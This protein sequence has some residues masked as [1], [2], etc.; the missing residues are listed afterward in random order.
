[1]NKITKTFV[2]GD[3]L[4]ASDLNDIV[5]SVNGIVD[6][7][8]TV[9][10]KAVDA[11]GVTAEAEATKINLKLP[12]IA[13]GSTPA[14]VAL[15]AVSSTKAGLFTPDMKS[16]LDGK[17]DKA[18]T[19]AGYEI[20]DAYTKAE[21]DAK[22]DEKIN[23]LDAEKSGSD[24][25]TNANIT[26]KVKEVDGKV[27]GVE[28]TETR[29]GSTRTA[30][31][32]HPATAADVAAGKAAKE[33]DL[34]VD[35]NPAVALTS[36]WGVATGD[37]IKNV[38]EYSEDVAK[39]EAAA[40]VAAMSS[41]A[42]KTISSH[43]I[44]GTGD[45]Q[46][47]SEDIEHSYS[48]DIFDFEDVKTG[49]N[50]MCATI[51]DNKEAIEEVKGDLLDLNVTDTA[52]DGKYVSAVEQQAGLI[53]VTREDLPVKEIKVTDGAT[54]NTSAVSV[55]SGVVSIVPAVN[56]DT[57]KTDA[58]QPANDIMSSKAVAAYV[59]NRLGDL[60][61]A[62]IYKGNVSSSSPLPAV[63]NVGDTY[64]V[65]EAGTYAGQDA[66]V[67]AMLI[68]ATATPLTWTLVKQTP[69]VENK[70]A[71]IGN[72]LTTLAIVNGIS[73]TAKVKKATV[74]DKNATI[75][76]TSTELATVDGVAIHAALPAGSSSQAGLVK[77]TDTYSAT[78]SD[79]ASGKAVASAIQNFKVEDVDTAADNG[80]AL[81]LSSKKVKV[82]VDAD[83]APVENSEKMV[84]SGGLY[85][86]F[87]KYAKVWHGTQAEYDAIATKDAN[88]LYLITE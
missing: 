46:L 1:M 59:S 77:V 72:D 6:E 58:Q 10:Q 35:T 36:Q 60:A 2:A 39:K 32:S 3:I 33:G 71:E 22:I 7:V 55:T 43:S 12:T 18:T 28:V 78:S 56:I 37:D 79:A 75:G 50:E 81:A 82:T 67:G 57:T 44:E 42:V 40:A 30:M 19:L 62:M 24:A 48:S 9:E 80:V 84:T 76:T 14:V 63:A 88:T 27:D 8:T 26:V 41:M 68:A 86:E 45:L 74:V 25:A 34:V 49:I 51:E 85:N 70:A 64:V 21:T 29:V 31:V 53:A 38:K 54:A 83:T 47:K 15:P 69:A 73:V 66:P 65:T 52:V 5:S 13:G 11:S 23:A 61:G 4:P 17:A 20:A 87:L 16:D